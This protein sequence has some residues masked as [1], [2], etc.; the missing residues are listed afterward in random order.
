MKELKAKIKSTGGSLGNNMPMI[1]VCGR[2]RLFAIPIAQGKGY[3][4]WPVSM[5]NAKKAADNVAKALGIKL[6]WEEK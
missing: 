1:Y 4:M 6:I 2:W 3:I 5:A